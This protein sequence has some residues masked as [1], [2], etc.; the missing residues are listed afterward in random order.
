[1]KTTPRFALA[2]QVRAALLLLACLALS[3]CTPMLVDVLKQD[4]RDPDRYARVRP[5]ELAGVAMVYRNGRAQPVN[6]P[7][8]LR[9]GDVIQTGPDAVARIRFPEG[10]EVILDVNTRAR[11][12]SFFVEFGR[13]LARA[14]GFFEAESENVVAGVG[15]TEFVFQVPRDRSVMVTVLDGAVVCRSRT[16]VYPPVRLRRGETFIARPSAAVPDT[17]LATPDEREDIRRWISQV[18]GV[19]PPPRDMD[20]FCCDGGRVFETSRGRCRGRFFAER[21]VAE[22]SCQ[23]PRPEFGYCCSDGEVFRTARERCR[24]SFHLE[25][26][27]AERACKRAPQGFCCADGRVFES[28]REQCRGRFFP[29]RGSAEKYC[30]PPPEPGYCC[31]DGEVSRSTREQCRGSFHRD[32]AEARTACRRAIELPRRFPPGGARPYEIVPRREPAAP[33]IK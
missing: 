25:Q 6:L 29:D 4:P 8:Q 9:P 5:A 18:D 1:M 24:G 33:D 3:G 16:G 14:R 7:Y 28:G 26:Y 23:P 27:D 17:R 13:I 22:A 31:S 2:W 19:V 11:L 20:G 15:G 12:G 21:G 10:H 30:R 32:A